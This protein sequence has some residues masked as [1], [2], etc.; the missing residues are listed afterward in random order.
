[1]RGIYLLV[2]LLPLLQ[3]YHVQRHPSQFSHQQK[4][5]ATKATIPEPTDELIA[6]R[7]GSLKIIR[8]PPDEESLE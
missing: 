4:L 2:L 7:D 6:F 8:M 5:F 3:S 1:M